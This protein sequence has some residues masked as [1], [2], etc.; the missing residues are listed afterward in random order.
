M[1]I[2]NLVSAA[3]WYADVA[4]AAFLLLFVLAGALRGFGKSTK[5][6][7]VFVFV[8]CI[9]LLLTGM[10][11]T[12]AVEGSLG[13][14]ISEGIGSASEGWGVAFNSPVYTDDGENYSI[15]VNDELVPLGG[16]DFGV[17]G[18]LAAFIAKSFHVEDGQSVAGAAVAS[19]TNICVAAILVAG[20]LYE[21]NFVRRQFD[22]FDAVLEVLYE[23]VDRETAV[24]DDVLAVQKS[25]I[26][27]K[28]HLH[29][30]I[31]HNEIKEFDLWIAEAVT[32]VRDKEWKDAIIHGL[33]F[34]VEKVF[35]L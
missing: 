15:L 12:A 2:G 3:S 7:F 13:K 11:Q 14:S 6:F 19:V 4:V 22:E 9:S 10:T 17:K 30:F 33:D 26:D 25:W 28:K 20:T 35:P 1:Y 27:K 8:V 18:S 23:K 29:I 21:T 31:S 34:D 32:L 24:Q 5:G 16:S